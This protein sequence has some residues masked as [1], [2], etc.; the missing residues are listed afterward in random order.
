MSAEHFEILRSAVFT[1][2][3]LQSRLREPATSA[4]AF[5]ARVVAVSAERGLDVAA[6]DVEAAMAEGRRSWLERWLR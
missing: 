2:E 3:A 6:A 1:D 5:V 4:D